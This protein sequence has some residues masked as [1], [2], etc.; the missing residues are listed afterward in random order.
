MICQQ[1]GKKEGD[2]FNEGIRQR[3]ILTEATR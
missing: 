2:T 3:S 1:R